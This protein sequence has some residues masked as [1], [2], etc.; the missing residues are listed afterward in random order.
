MLSSAT[1]A[2]CGSGFSCELTY[3]WEGEG[4]EGVTVRKPP[5]RLEGAPGYGVRGH[6]PVPGLRAPR[7]ALSAAAA[8]RGVRQVLR[9]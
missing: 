1:F 5:A 9:D 6:V 8:W 7:E 3:Y 2:M 4:D